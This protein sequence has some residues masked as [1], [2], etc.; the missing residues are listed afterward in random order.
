MLKRDDVIDLIVRHIEA[1]PAP[2]GGLP[3]ARGRLFLSEY[4]IKKRLTPGAQL[5]TIPEGAI[6]SP[7]ALD[8]LAL[9]G[10]KI[11]RQQ[12]KA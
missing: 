8:W 10:I 5:L 9:G 2:G 7:L 12:G 3:E 11:V 4:E 1:E 6:I